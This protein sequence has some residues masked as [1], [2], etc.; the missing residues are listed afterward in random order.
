MDEKFYI[1]KETLSGPWIHAQVVP[2][3]KQQES[4]MVAW[5][6]RDPHTSSF[7]LCT[8]S[9]APVDPLT[10]I[11]GVI[12]RGSKIGNHAPAQAHAHV[13]SII[14][15]HRLLIVDCCCRSSIVNC[16][17][18][19]SLIDCCCRSSILGWSLWWSHRVNIALLNGVSHCRRHSQYCKVFH[20]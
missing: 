10:F 13:L 7:D 20:T 16:C 1:C 12:D 6:W 18:W 19:S 15:N 14:V 17:C 5:S 3:L 4:T 11:Q 2:K 9:T 8:I